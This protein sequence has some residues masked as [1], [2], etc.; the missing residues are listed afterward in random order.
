MIDWV[1]IVMTVMGFIVT[2]LFGLIG[3][4]FRMVFSDIKE[5]EEKNLKLDK[6][7]NDHKL[8]AAEHFATKPDVDRGF[9][10][11]LTKLDSIDKKTD[12]H[13][14]ALDNKINSKVDKQ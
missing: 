13:L 14:A 11:I 5:V 8:H 6:S 4:V 10:R 2:G 7:L 3:W 1:S 9:D 12:L